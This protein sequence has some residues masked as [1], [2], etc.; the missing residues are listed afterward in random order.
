MLHFPIALHSMEWF[1]LASPVLWQKWISLDL[2]RNDYILV[3]LSAVEVF[4]TKF[5]IYL[6]KLLFSFRELIYT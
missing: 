3:Q 6:H 2:I 1:T 5:I 4:I